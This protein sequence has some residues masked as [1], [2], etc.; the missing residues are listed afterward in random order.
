MNQAEQ[1]F[2]SGN[3]SSDHGAE[4]KVEALHAKIGELTMERGFYPKH[5]VKT[6]DR[7]T[8]P[9]SSGPRILA[10]LRWPRI[11]VLG[12]DHGPAYP[13]GAGLAGVVHPGHALLCGSP[14]IFN[15][16]LRGRNLLRRRSPGCRR[17]MASPSAGT[18]KA[19]GWTMC[20]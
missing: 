2:E 8:A 15:T 13:Q 17:L 14:M 3:A 4:E 10:R 5:P 6:D 18:A 9:I 11:H 16:D 20:S 1:V 7:S 19:A 12:G